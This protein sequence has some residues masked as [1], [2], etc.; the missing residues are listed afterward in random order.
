MSADTSICHCREIF[1]D[2]LRFLVL[3]LLLF[4]VFRAPAQIIDL[5]GNG[6][7]DIWEWTYNVYGI[8][9]NTDPDGDGFTNWQEAIAGT[10]P[11]NANSYLRIPSI[12]STRTNAS[13]TIYSYPGKMYTLECITNLS[14][15]VW[16][17]ATNVEAQSGT[18]LTFIVPI[19]S[20]VQVCR[21]G[22]SD[23]NSDGT[24]LMTD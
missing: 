20:V 24:G 21:V 9:P 17:V 5:N 8:D 7:S 11:L 4:T 13:I 19:S 2:R 23:V 10:D 18:N 3:T 6:M 12:I 22:V 16:V 15:P 14:D 1:S